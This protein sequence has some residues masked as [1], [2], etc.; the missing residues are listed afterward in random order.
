MIE[1]R[2]PFAVIFAGTPFCRSLRASPRWRKLARMMRL[3][4]S[5][6]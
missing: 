4:N 6:M 1:Q 2:N 5:G 3:P